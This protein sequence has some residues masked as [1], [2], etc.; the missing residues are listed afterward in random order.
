MYIFFHMI[1]NFLSCLV[2][3]I[4]VDII[5]IAIMTVKRRNHGRNKHGRGHVKRV[6]WVVLCADSFVGW[7][8]VICNITSIY[9]PDYS[10]LQLCSHS[11]S[12][13]YPYYN[14]KNIKDVHPPERLFPRIR[15][16][17]VSSYVTSL[18]HHHLEILRKL[19]HTKSTNFPSF[20]LRCTTV[21][22][23]LCIN[24]LSVD[25]PGK[26]VGLELHQSESLSVR[27]KWSEKEKNI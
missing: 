5:Y 4:A 22:R 25:V 7:L 6:R 13:H 8:L 17:S 3:P 26:D 20:T 24:V 12:I 27:V 19:L 11:L 16:S 2:P 18:M 15:P 1:S 14:I 23:L 10:T 9:I 21:L